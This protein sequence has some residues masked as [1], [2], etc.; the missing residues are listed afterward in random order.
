MT[1]KNKT[2]RTQTKNLTEGV[3]WKQ[4]ISLSTPLLLTSCLQALYGTV[5]LLILGN[6]L[7]ETAITAVS[8]SSQ[9]MQI[10]TASS[11]GFGVAGTVLISKGVGAG[12][13][14]QQRKQIG[15]IISMFVI[16]SVVLMLLIGFI[17]AVPML[18]LLNVP[19]QAF[20]EALIY[21]RICSLGMIFIFGYNIISAILRGVGDTTAVLL[22]CIVAAVGNVG[23][24]ILFVLVI[25]WGIAG[26][27]WATVIAQ[28][29]AF[30][31]SMMYM[32]RKS[33]LDM[34][35]KR[36]DFKMDV[37]I[38]KQVFQIGIPSAIQ[39]TIVHL[40]ML[41]LMRLVNGHDVTV[42]A[43]YGIG[44]KVDSFATLPR[45]AIGSSA[46][47][48]VGQN[49]GAKNLERIQKTIRQTV[50]MGLLLS[51][52]VMVIV[53]GLAPHIVGLFTQ[54][55]AVI[56][57]GIRY[58]RIISLGYP[59][60]GI[61]SGLNALPLGIGYTK[62]TLFISIV[63]SL[64]VRVPL[65][66]LLNIVMYPNPAGIYI[67]ATIAPIAAVALGFWYFKTKRWIK[68]VKNAEAF[69]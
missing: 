54:E 2:P 42:A 12:K 62:F 61:M 53:L 38:V 19:A 50:G 49:A 67:G 40:S 45:Q 57:E 35:R 32:Y 7:G 43:A 10:L 64:G 3:I 23:L 28:G 20:E 25:P 15:T 5:D 9:V 48:I 66:T 18:K 4:L 68:Q 24:D 34:P 60:L 8:V 69:S 65:C 47:V 39:V 41:L 31:L 58:L 36:S 21:L 26:A 59:I 55:E 56:Q 14:N 16:I 44:L 46:A 22:M 1:Y 33:S 27:A 52:I 51:G 6:V 63:D 13:Q 17:L 37:Q 30:A 11:I 29:S